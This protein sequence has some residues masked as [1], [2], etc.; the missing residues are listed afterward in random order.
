MIESDP[1]EAEW[2]RGW[3]RA[4]RHSFQLTSRTCFWTSCHPLQPLPSLCGGY[5]RPGTVGMSPGGQGCG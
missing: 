1:P 5:G 2:Q 4:W 3:L